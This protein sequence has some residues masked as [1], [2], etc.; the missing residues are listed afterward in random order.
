MADP[1]E[2]EQEFRAFASLSGVQLETCTARE[3]LTAMLRFY[4][5]QRVDGCAVED[6]GDMLLFQWGTYDFGEGL[7]FRLDLTRQVILPDQ[8]D[9]DAIW[10][11]NFAYLFA[12]MPAL[13]QLGSGDRWCASPAELP[14][15]ERFVQ[16]HAAFRA[17]ADARPMALDMYFENVG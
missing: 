1:L 7:N 9:D 11:L 13:D 2:L 8:E 16:E 10:Q 14:E 3:G 15:F 4:E 17:V 5:S 6:D 12:P